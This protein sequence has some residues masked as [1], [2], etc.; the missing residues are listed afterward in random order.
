[1][2]PHP[3]L[4]IAACGLA[5]AGCFAAIQKD[6]YIRSK[7][8]D[9]AYQMPVENVWPEVTRLLK[10]QGYHF[11]EDPSSYVLTTDWK[12][13]LTGSKVSG[14]FTRYVVQGARLDPQRSAV[15]FLR[16]SKLVYDDRREHSRYPTQGN[17]G[18]DPEEKEGLSVNDL[19]YMSQASTGELRR[20]A[21]DNTLQGLTRDFNLEWLLLQRVAPEHAS[22][23]E[24]RAARQ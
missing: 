24:A 13:D 2:R 15:R 3:S 11:I 6:T 23:I 17:T 22:E 21:S 7:V 4:S 9:Y 8:G 5:L 18:V 1:M 12:E 10:D 19:R 14:S 16:E 20:G